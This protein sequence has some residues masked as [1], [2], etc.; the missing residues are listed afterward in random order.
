[1]YETLRKDYISSSSI[2]MIADCMV[3]SVNTHGVIALAGMPCVEYIWH[4]YTEYCHFN[5]RRMISKFKGER[6]SSE[7]IL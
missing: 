6:T 7:N 4:Q 2:M 3:M 1:M 5:V